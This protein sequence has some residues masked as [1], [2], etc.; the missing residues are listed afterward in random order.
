MVIPSKYPFQLTFYQ[1]GEYPINDFY[2]DPQHIQSAGVTLIENMEFSIRF[3]SNEPTIKLYMDGLDLLPAEEVMTDE[4][5]QRYLPPNK[6]KIPLFKN[7]TTHLPWIPGLYLIKI[8]T[9]EEEFYS[10]LQINPKQLTVSQWEQMRQEIESEIKGLTK[11]FIQNSFQ[12]ASLQSVSLKLLNQF[13]FIKQKF[14]FILSSLRDLMQKGSQQIR[15]KYQLLPVHQ[16][17]WIDEK[18]IR[19]Q[20]KYPYQ[21]HLLAPVYQVEMD[22]PENQWIKQIIFDLNKRLLQ[23]IQAFEQYQLELKKANQTLHP[24]QYQSNTQMKIEK[25]AQLLDKI[26]EYIQ[27]TKRMQ[28][29]ISQFLQMDWFQQI[30]IRSQKHIPS[31]LILDSRYR[32]LFQIYQTLK[33]NKPFSLNDQNIT[34]NY[35]RTDLLYE[36]WGFI[37]ICKTLSKLGFQ[38]EQKELLVQQNASEQMIT[39]HLQSGTSIV[40]HRKTLR[41]IITYDEE[42]PLKPESS[43]CPLYSIG[44]SKRPDIRLDLYME[45]TYIGSLIFECKYRSLD[46]IWQLQR[47]Y[48]IKR[49]LMD[50]AYFTKSNKIF[51]HLPATIRNQ[52]RPVYQVWALYPTP[53]H[54]SQTNVKMIKVDEHIFLFQV[55]PGNDHQHFIT[56]LQALLDQIESEYKGYQLIKD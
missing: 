33:S 15:K 38:A 8:E 56:S 50:Y 16:V 51:H 52:I 11:E 24:Y 10:L 2:R 30:S 37:T 46:Q 18:S 53:N 19:H 44:I 6:K 42:I 22:I 29:T 3:Y 40:F 31:A 14:P 34:L 55:S 23:M 7:H 48:E 35:K 5:G 27:Q 4:K 25:N 9:P 20:L 47:H 49:Q 17:K 1:K 32:N 39:P 21:K 43:H 41:A 13:S 28:K 45:Q 54:P 26:Q 36:I 12:S